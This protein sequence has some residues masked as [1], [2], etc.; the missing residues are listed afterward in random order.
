MEG[1]SNSVQIWEASAYRS[2]RYTGHTIA[3]KD[4]LRHVFG[5]QCPHIAAVTGAL[6]LLLLLDSPHRAVASGPLPYR[7]YSTRWIMLRTRPRDPNWSSGLRDNAGLVHRAC[8]GRRSGRRTRRRISIDIRNVDLPPSGHATS[9]KA[10]PL[11][12]DL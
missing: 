12:N 2:E 6:H 7:W 10:T 5:I 11:Q 3:V 4:I 1:A 9:H 8:R